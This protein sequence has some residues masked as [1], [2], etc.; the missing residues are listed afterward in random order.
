MRKERLSFVICMLLGLVAVK[1]NHSGVNEAILSDAPA[2]QVSIVE[3][4]NTFKEIDFEV[5][6]NKDSERIIVK[7]NENIA[8]VSVIIKDD[9]G[10][11][12]LI[13]H[14]RINNAAMFDVLKIGEGTYFLQVKSQAEHHHATF[15]LKLRR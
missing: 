3:V 7:W 10:K 9:S 12:I 1:G 4:E 13:E 15:K 14:P 11:T 2:V 6:A 5:K 8:D